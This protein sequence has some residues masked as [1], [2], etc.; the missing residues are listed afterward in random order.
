MIYKKLK[1]KSFGALGENCQLNRI[2][3]GFLLLGHEIVENEDCDLIFVN[4]TGY[5]KEGIEYKKKF[6][7][8]KLILSILDLPFHVKEF[9]QIID[10]LNQNFYN[11]DAITTISE[12]VKSQMYSYL[13]ISNKIP[14]GVIYQPIKPVYPLNLE[15]KDRFLFVGRAC[16]SNKRFN[17]GL[18][19]AGLTNKIIDVVGSEDPTMMSKPQYRKFINYL[20]VIPDEQLNIEYNT[21]LATLVTGKV[22]GI[23]LSLI[24]SLCAQTPVICL[25][26]MATVYEFCPSNFI[27]RVNLYDLSEKFRYIQSGNPEIKNTL[28]KYSEKYSEQF[29]PKQVANNIIKVYESIRK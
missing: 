7:N 24:E 11:A 23:S 15:K 22:E 6:P 14:F 21:H 29:S 25:D 5:H 13:S 3:N 16:D 10:N 1:I 2:N 9:N 4:D 19:L 8:S 28:N 18:E 17:I 12:T 26:D 20:G 27:S